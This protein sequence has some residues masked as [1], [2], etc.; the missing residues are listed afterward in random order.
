MTSKG[1]LKKVIGQASSTNEGVVSTTDYS[2]F[3]MNGSLSVS[4]DLPGEVHI[5]STTT[6]STPVILEQ[7][8]GISLTARIE[9]NAVVVTSLAPVI[10]S[11]DGAPSSTPGKIGDIYVDTTNHKLYFAEGSDSSADWILAN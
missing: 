8:S 6:N 7:G 11:G 5:D 2:L 3:A 9:D 4:D 10:T 1:R